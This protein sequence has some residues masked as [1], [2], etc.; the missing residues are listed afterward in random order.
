MRYTENYTVTSHDVDIRNHLRPSLLQ[1]YLME[2]ADHQMRDRK[3]SYG[4][5]FS[6][7][8]AFI[9]TRISIEVFKQIQKYDEIQVETWRCPEKGATFIRCFTVL[10]RGEL[11]AKGYSVWAVVNHQT[12]KL[13]RASEVDLS[14]YETEQP[15]E[16]QLPERFRLPKDVPFVCAGEKTVF[17]SDVDINLHMNNTHYADMLWNFIPEVWEKEITS[18]NL[19]FLKEAPL[20]ANVEVYRAELGTS[21]PEDPRAEEIWCFYSKVNGQTNVEAQIGV[22]TIG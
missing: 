11:M 3:P 16:M 8:K 17:Y 2:T 18:V 19:R 4:E 12:G 15:H 10:C 6:Q 14:N 13:Y 7:G 20:G 21:L 22:K 5:F 9:L 1:R